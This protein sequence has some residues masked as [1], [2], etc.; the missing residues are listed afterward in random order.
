MKRIINFV[1]K[2]PVAITALT[3]FMF[4]FLPFKPKSFGDGQFHSGTQE[5]IQFILNGFQGNVHID[6]GFLTLFCY[7][8]PYSLV[9]SFHNDNLFFLSGVIFS[10]FFVCY[11]VYLLFKALD[12]LK[13]DNRSKFTTLLL[14]CIFPVHIYYAMGIIGEVFAFFSV[15]VFVFYWVKITQLKTNAISD[16]VF[17]ALSLVLLYGIK[18]TMIPFILAFTF[19]LL[20]LKIKLVHKIGFILFV[21]LIPIFGFIEKKM[22][23]SEFDF[24]STVFRNQIL[25]SRFELR[26]EPFNW[27]PQHGRDGFESSDYLH[28]LAKR[29]ELD[30]ICDVNKLDKTNYYVHWVIKD[31]IHNPLL[32]LRQYT[33]KFFQSQ[34]FIISP[35]MKSNKSNFIKYGIHVYINSINYI[36]ILMSLWSMYRLLK[37]KEYQFFIPFLILWGWSL[38]YVFVFHSEQRYMFPIRPMLVI[39]FAYAVN[40]FRIDKNLN[41]KLQDQN[42]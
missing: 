37:N 1:V 35:L 24:K 9:Y 25:W 40:Q 30:S 31:I 8:I 14:L 32:T 34:S 12:I 17:L 21:L 6:K 3:C 4:Y 7:L 5:L 19:Y 39:L 33:L 16:Y 36:L 2:Y 41:K 13:F 29:S 15:S 27:M 22:D 20:F 38:A 28:N 23:T 11:S 26:D 18:P 10:C 42:N